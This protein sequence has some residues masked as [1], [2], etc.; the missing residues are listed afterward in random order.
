MKIVE[1]VL[2]VLLALVFLAVGVFR[3][4]NSSDRADQAELLNVPGWFLILVSLLE[5]ALAIDLLIPRFRIL[6]GVGIAIVMVGAVILNLFGTTVND[7]NPR[8]FIPGN[9]VLVLLALLTAWLASGRVKSIGSLIETAK[10]QAMGQVGS[11]AETVTD[12]AA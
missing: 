5:I 6:G 3:L 11:A 4:I 8:T 2:A 7:V 10:N 1:W 9:I 12:L